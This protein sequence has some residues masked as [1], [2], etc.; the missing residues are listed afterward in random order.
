MT[1]RM[2]LPCC[3]GCLTSWPGVLDLWAV[4]WS[5]AAGLY[6]SITGNADLPGRRGL[7]AHQGHPMD[8]A[9]C[10]E[11]P[12]RR[13]GGMV[14]H[15]HRQRGAGPGNPSRLWLPGPGL[16]NPH[17]PSLSAL[18]IFGLL[19]L[20]GSSGHGQH[21]CRIRR[22][23]DTG[24]GAG[25]LHR[26]GAAVQQLAGGQAGHGLHRVLPQ[27]SAAD[28]V[29][30]LVLHHPDPAAGPGELRHRWRVVHPQ[31][32]AFHAL[33]PSGRVG[34]FAGMGLAGSRIA[35]CRMVGLPIPDSPRD[36][37]GPVVIPGAYR[38]VGSDIPGGG[39]VDCCQPGCRRLAVLHF[40][41]G[42]TGT[43]RAD[44]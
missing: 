30:L 22:G 21:H 24:Y 31:R 28:S 8:L 9:D 39:H 12:C 41:A 26:G 34:A 25:H 29:V 42:A 40:L 44:S 33:S 3:S 15:Q 36:P 7:A 13:L 17:R 19:W 38:V 11:H 10:V 1:G 27:C 20:R 18:R 6:G 2:R 43:L 14:L 4:T 32:R 23:R 16:P 35:H 37:N 5:A